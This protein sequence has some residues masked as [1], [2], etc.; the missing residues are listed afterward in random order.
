MNYV[1]SEEPC[2]VLYDSGSIFFFFLMIHGGVEFIHNLEFIRGKARSGRH[3]ER[4]S[5]KTIDR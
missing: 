4:W 2:S 5:F 1:I 3:K